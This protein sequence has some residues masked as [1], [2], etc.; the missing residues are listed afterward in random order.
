MKVRIDTYY[1]LT[2]DSCARSWS[3]DFRVDDRRMDVN[4]DGGMGMARSKSHLSKAAYRAGWKCFRG[5][6]LCP[7]C[8]ERERKDRNG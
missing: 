6:I 3:T 7:E 4:G 8:L 2:C 5:R 1:D